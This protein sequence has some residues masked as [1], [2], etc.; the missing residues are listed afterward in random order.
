MPE[1]HSLFLAVSRQRWYTAQHCWDTL[2]PKT[3]MKIMKFHLCTWYSLPGDYTETHLSHS[4]QLTSEQSVTT[5]CK[6]R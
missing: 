5:Y 1:P 4:F 3:M 2:Y 6:V